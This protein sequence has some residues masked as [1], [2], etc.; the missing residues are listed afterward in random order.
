MARVSVA[1]S[2]R[3]K[4]ARMLEIRRRSISTRPEFSFGAVAGPRVEAGGNS[5][6]QPRSHALTLAAAVQHTAQARQTGGGSRNLGRAKGP[7]SG[8]DLGTGGRPDA[9]SLACG[10][11][12]GQTSATAR[13][14]SSGTDGLVSLGGAMSL[15]PQ[16]SRCCCRRRGRT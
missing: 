1:E 10:R 5:E 7:D 15:L 12:D 3:E 13:G 8:P 14:R 4:A 11:C 16:R 2:S 9:V 6:W